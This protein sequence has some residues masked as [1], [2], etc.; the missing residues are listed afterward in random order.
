MKPARII[1]LAVS[2]LTLT[3][4]GALAYKALCLN[5][6]EIRSGA[7]T[8]CDKCKYRPDPQDSNLLLFSVL[9]SDHHQSMETLLNFGKVIK[10]I[11]P[12]CRT[13]DERF[14][15]FA[16]YVAENYPG[17]LREVRLPDAHKDR[18]PRILKGLK[19]PVFEVEQPGLPGQQDKEVW[20]ESPAAASPSDP[21]KPTGQNRK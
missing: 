7:W 17:L 21:A 10:K 19:L 6:G 11:A 1:F 16:S 18:V 5:C 12:A 3:A 8:A 15:V 2:I 13:N 20:P 14:L 9:F 4:T